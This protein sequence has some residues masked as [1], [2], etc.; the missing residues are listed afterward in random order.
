MEAYPEAKAIITTRDYESWKR[1]MDKTIWPLR[2]SFGYRLL[3]RFDEFRRAWWPF[4]C[5]VIDTAYGGWEENG[6]EK[7]EEHH[8]RMRALVPPGKLL[9][10]SPKEGWEPLCTY[11]DAPI[12]DT[13]FPHVNASQT[14]EK[15]G[16]D[17]RRAL[18]KKAAVNATTGVVLASVMVVALRWGKQRLLR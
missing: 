6:E 5:L 11:L 4:M 14:L 17:G 3:Y 9:E 8:R 1:S 12:P 2:H 7:Y 15:Q 13:P 16:R 10:F 18:W